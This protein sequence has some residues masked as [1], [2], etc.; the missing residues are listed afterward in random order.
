L[1]AGT[2]LGGSK[3]KAGKNRIVP[4]HSR[5]AD[6]VHMRMSVGGEYLWGTSKN[7]RLCVTRPRQNAH[8]PDV[9]SAFVAGASLDFDVFRAS[10]F[11]YSGRRCDIARYYAIWNEIMERT[12]MNHT[13]HECRHTLRSWL[14]RAGANRVAIN[15][16]MGHAGADTGER[17]YTHKTLQELKE[18]IELVTR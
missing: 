3:T 14:D 5:V 18:A 13:P 6:S 17:V 11:M 8:L 10:L 2:M 16:I 15:K 4:I 1:E 9:N 12:G 7:S